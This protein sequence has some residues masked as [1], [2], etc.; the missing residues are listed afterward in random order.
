MIAIQ[1]IAQYNQRLGWSIA[2]LEEM[3]DKKNKQA[4]KE[5]EFVSHN[6]CVCVFAL[7]M[8]AG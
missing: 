5:E 3:L 7:G 2:F 4:G 6:T 8:R 1:W